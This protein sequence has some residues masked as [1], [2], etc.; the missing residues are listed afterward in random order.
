MLERLGSALTP[1]LIMAGG[2]F[3]ELLVELT[4]LFVG[5]IRGGLSAAVVVASADHHPPVLCHHFVKRFISLI[6]SD[7]FFR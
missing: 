6:K 4:E 7:V 2:R 3:A 5:K 1:V